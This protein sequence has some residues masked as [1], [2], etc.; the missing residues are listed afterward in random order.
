MNENIRFNQIGP[1][2]QNN[3]ENITLTFQKEQTSQSPLSSEIFVGPKNCEIKN[4]DIQS[5]QILAQKNI[6][7]IKKL[8]IGHFFSLILI[9]LNYLFIIKQANGMFCF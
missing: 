5:L 2:F 3:E 6:T 9:Y 7:S 4:N 1:K 8:P